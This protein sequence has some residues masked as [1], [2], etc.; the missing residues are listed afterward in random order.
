MKISSSLVQGMRANW[1]QFALLV[2]VNAFVGAMLGLERTIVPLIASKDFGLT[3][4]S[5]TLSFIISFGI[6]KAFANVFTGRNA[7]RYGRKPLLRLGW[8]FALPVPFLVIFAPSWE[9]IVFAN[10]LLGLNQ[11]LCWS[12]TVMM[13]IDLVG[14]KERGRA[15]GMNEFAGYFA[16]A[17]STIASSWIAEQ[18]ALRPYP[19]YLGIGF[20]SIGLILSF[21]FVR[22]TV[23][24][25]RQ[26]ALN[27]PTT[28]DEKPSFWTIFRLVSWQ[29]KSF[30]SLSQAGLINNLN[31]V[32]IWGLLP[33]LALQVGMSAPEV[34]RIGG[35]YLVVW[36]ISQLGTG[37]L[38]D[39]IGRKPLITGG[40]WLQSL[41]IF[42]F[43]LSSGE[44]AWLTA[45]VIMG[46]G[47][48]MVYPTLLASISDHAH[49]AW[50][51]SALG[52][53]RLWRDSGYA[54]GALLA[55]ILSDVFNLATAI[56]TIAVLTFIAGLL[57][58]LYLTEAN[59][60]VVPRQNS[61]T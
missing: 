16:M 54:F 13:K 51:A 44:T 21:F 41:G 8:L 36:G 50:R 22:E 49:P 7:D 26:E 47:T 12:S 45:A 46:L 18:T 53:Y 34:A 25:A 1:Q 56:L 28:A 23:S 27:Y 5:V 17:A 57:S 61:A 33:L 3:S 15:T 20:V 9:W 29:N 39:L 52:I 32:V 55:G 43:V 35:T 11:G 37:V 42:F 58:F 14:A 59:K 19:F 31:D 4:V 30:F 38:S 24:Y 60:R 2:L 48:G 10:L 6:V 40:L